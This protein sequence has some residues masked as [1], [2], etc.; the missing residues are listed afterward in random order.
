MANGAPKPSPKFSGIRK[1]WREDVVKLLATGA[2]AGLAAVVGSALTYLATMRDVELKNRAAMRDMELKYQ[3][4]NEVAKLQND[5]AVKDLNL[6]M[7]D[8]SLAIL[9][10]EKGGA[11]EPANADGYVLARDFAIKALSKASDIP[12]SDSDRA[13]WAKAGAI[14][15]GSVPSPMS[16][17]MPVEPNANAATAGLVYSDETQ[18]HLTVCIG[19]QFA[20]CPPGTK[21]H[22]TC[23]TDIKEITSR[24]CPA[25]DGVSKERQ[26]YGGNRCGYGVYD[27]TCNS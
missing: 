14:Q 26:V 11:D 16:A 8:L 1:W 9:A 4:L 21:N 20:R 10:G 22:F 5:T 15:L 24:A 23:Y 27:I 19:E 13:K 17:S 6:K 18:T 25:N 12:V 3:N 2:V 7:I